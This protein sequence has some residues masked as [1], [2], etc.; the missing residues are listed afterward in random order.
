MCPSPPSNHGTGVGGSFDSSFW[1]L[2]N[3]HRLG[4]GI[5]KM[6]YTPTV[7]N[8][9]RD[10]YFKKPFWLYF[11]DSCLQGVKH[12]CRWA[13]QGECVAPGRR[14]EFYILFEESGRLLPLV[15][16]GSFEETHTNYS[17]NIILFYWYDY[18]IKLIYIQDSLEVEHV[19]KKGKFWQ[20]LLW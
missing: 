3:S 5:Y 19:I 18:G 6:Q 9:G 10:F 15:V 4:C 20:L 17:Y 12:H 8:F 11:F 2:Q 14:G 13:F 1:G 7:S 16:Q